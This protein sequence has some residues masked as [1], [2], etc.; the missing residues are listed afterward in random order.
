MV[1]IKIKETGEQKE[2]TPNIAHDLID[3]GIAELVKITNA[4]S[5]QTFNYPNRQMTS[6][7][8][9]RWASRRRQMIP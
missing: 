7:R 4:Y 9:E 1:K 5:H 3:R 8:A 2:V 6:S